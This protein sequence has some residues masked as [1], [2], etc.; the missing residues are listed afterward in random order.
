MLGK[1]EERKAS[2]GRLERRKIPYEIEEPLGSFQGEVPS[3]CSLWCKR[4]VHGRTRKGKMGKNLKVKE[5]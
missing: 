3:I 4:S 5:A 2:K 1:R